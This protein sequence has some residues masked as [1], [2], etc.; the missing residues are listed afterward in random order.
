VSLLTTSTRLSARWTAFYT[1]GLPETQRSARRAEITSDLW[2]HT[3]FDID[4]GENPADTGFE[5]LMRTL[6]G[7]PADLSWRRSIARSAPNRAARFIPNGERTMLSRFLGGLA[8]VFTVFIGVFLIANSF[9]GILNGSTT[10]MLWVI[11]GELIP[12][13]LMI[14]GVYLVHRNPRLGTTM[15]IAGAVIAASVH[16]WMAFLGVP[17]A[18]AIILGSLSRGGMIGNKT[19]ATA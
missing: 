1:N 2:E 10:D 9:G 15:T 3:Q 11:P 16:F 5:I 4:A 8:T 13:V 7:I 12:G 18:V 19:S 17:V 14:A 6:F